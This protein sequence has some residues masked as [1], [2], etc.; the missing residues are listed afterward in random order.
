ML[1]VEKA[2][3]PDQASV[4]A[5][6]GKV[7]QVETVS[8]FLEDGTAVTMDVIIFISWE[9]IQELLGLIRKRAGIPNSVVVFNQ[10]G[11]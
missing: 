9:S 2:L 7:K 6:A 11:S 8:V 1:D 4:I 3:L 10:N 5:Y